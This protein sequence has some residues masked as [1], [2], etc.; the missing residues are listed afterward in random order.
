MNKQIFIILLLIQLVFGF[1]CTY[2]FAKKKIN[3]KFAYPAFFIDFV[4]ALF[5]YRQIPNTTYGLY[6]L[7]PKDFLISVLLTITGLIMI[8][9]LS[10][11]LELK[12]PNLRRYSLMQISRILLLYVPAVIMQQFFYQV[13]FHDVFTYLLYNPLIIYVLVSGI[14]FSIAHLSFRDKLFWQGASVTGFIFSLFYAFVPSIILISSMHYII[15]L[16][17]FSKGFIKMEGETRIF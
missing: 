11:N 7:E 12:K 8:K 16:Y 6:K 4:I 15:G 17:A 2:L 9:V 13:Y 3:I 14:M 10:G 1:T 5:L